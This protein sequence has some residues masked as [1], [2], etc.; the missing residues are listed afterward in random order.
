MLQAS[1]LPPCHTEPAT[2]HV[3]PCHTAQHFPTA[4][5]SCPPLLFTVSCGTTPIWARSE[6]CG[7]RQARILGLCVKAGTPAQG[8]L[9]GKAQG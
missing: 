6:P 3:C 7:R 9:D 8:R 5:P 4:H 1:S 2:Q